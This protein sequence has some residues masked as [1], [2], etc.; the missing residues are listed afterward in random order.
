MEEKMTRIENNLRK[1]GLGQ[2]IDN[3][4]IIIVNANEIE[5]KDDLEKKVNHILK[6]GGFKTGYGNWI[7]RKNYKSNE[8]IFNN[9]D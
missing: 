9:I 2:D 1:A 5:V 7:L 6:W 4:N 8:L 3:N